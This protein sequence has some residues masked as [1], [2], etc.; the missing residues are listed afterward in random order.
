MIKK[1]LL[2]AMVAIAFLMSCNKDSGASTTTFSCTGITPTY[3]STIKTILDNSCA[4]SGCHDAIYAARGVDL[5]TYASV[6][7]ASKQGSFMG[8]IEHQ[9]GYQA[10]PQ[11]TAKLP[12]ATIQKI[13]CW[14]QNGLPN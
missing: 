14:I 2:F 7:A 13:Y 9:A 10:M 8:T 6:K 12:D 11:G 4:V 3:T 1:F 5:S